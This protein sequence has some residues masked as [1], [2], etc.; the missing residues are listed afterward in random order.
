MKMEQPDISDLSKTLRFSPELGKIWR[1]GVRC[2]LLTDSVFSAMREHAIATIGWDAAQDSFWKM[3]YAEGERCASM[4]RTLRPG[5]SY[6][7]AFAVGPQAHALTGF[8]WT[9]ID[10]LDTNAEIGEFDGRFR[11]H[12]SFEA[13]LHLATSGVSADPVCWFQTGFASGFASRFAGQS[14]VMREVECVGMGHPACVLHARP[15]IDGESPVRSGA[16]RDVTL[17]VTDAE[18]SLDGVLGSS[19]R[20]IAA[21][22]M[23]LKVADSSA[24]LLLQGETGVGKEVFARLAHRR[25]KRCNAPFVSLNCAAIPEGLIEAELFGVVKGAFTG[26]T[27]ARPGRFERAQGGTL[28]LDEVSS[29]SPLAQSK[30]LRAIQEREIERVGDTKTTKVDIRLIVAS[31]VELKTA[32]KHGDFR[33]DLYY[34]LATCPIHIPPLRER[35]EDIPLLIEHFRR[36]FTALHARNVPNF[37][38]RGLDLLFMYD[39]PGNV[40]ELEAMI[41]RAVLLADENR[42]LD[43]R[44]LFPVGDTPDIETAMGLSALGAI[45]PAD[46]PSALH[47]L[48][49][50]AY[51]ILREGSSG[52]SDL[53]QQI[54]VHAVRAANGNISQ[55]A[56]DL[57][58]T[59]R[60]LSGRLPTRA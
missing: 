7:D 42:P 58:L 30:V 49:V 6:D 27:A 57:G 31:N 8:G 55:A 24:T 10:K 12:D 19:A 15:A 56:R 39:Y 54:V 33:T 53:E 40:R 41:E 11:V 60:Q 35:R 4:A 3:G 50:S 28:F 26:A 48:A 22:H 21:R 43:L 38:A 5:T 14:I 18:A 45:G 9:E 25:S 13:G 59:R 17:P 23:L 52:I 34:R 44:H 1:D 47:E 37:T 2:V 36:K 16:H 51:G 20:F 46:S 29:L 32:A